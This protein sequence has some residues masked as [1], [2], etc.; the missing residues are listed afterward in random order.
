MLLPALLVI[1]FMVTPRGRRTRLRRV[2]IRGVWLLIPVVAVTIAADVTRGMSPHDHAINRI[3]GALVVV[4][5][6]CFLLLNLRGLRDRLT[7]VAVLGVAV[8][9]AINAAAALVFGGMPI[10]GASARLAGY[11]YVPGSAAPSDYV[12]S[13]H[14]G[15][16]AIVIGD[17]IPI[18]GLMKVLSVGDLLLFAGLA[19]C[20]V[21]AVGNL[22]AVDP[23]AASLRTTATR[24]GEDPALLTG[25][26][27]PGVE[28]A[29][30]VE[31]FGG[32]R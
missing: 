16:G 2:S 1:G 13:D 9:G 27:M 21:A 8:G 24:G 22:L 4:A 18:P 3:E 11:D 15:L 25:D 10:L 12:Y 28:P 20:G 19:A 17:F 29:P 31:S 23:P 14:L 30:D 7:A 5:S 32:R 6:G 26:A